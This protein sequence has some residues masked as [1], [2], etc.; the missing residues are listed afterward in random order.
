MIL[1]PCLIFY[2]LL[3]YILF[4][5]I[6]YVCCTLSTIVAREL[7]RYKLDLVGAREVRLSKGGTVTACGLQFLLWKRKRNSIAN[8][9]FFYHRIVSAIKREDFV[10]YRIS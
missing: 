5:Y 7:A 3:T 1:Y 6:Y 8:S 4:I 10:S 9:F 2:C